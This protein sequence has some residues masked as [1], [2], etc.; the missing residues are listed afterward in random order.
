MVIGDK[1]L[2]A[3]ELTVLGFL[4]DETPVGLFFFWIDG[5][6]L[7]NP[8]DD[9][10]MRGCISW[11]R[12]FYED[13]GDRCEPE[14][15]DMELS[16]AYRELRKAMEGPLEE[17][18]DGR[19]GNI[20]SRF[21][22]EHIGMSSFDDIQI[23]LIEG[24]SMEQRFVWWSNP[25]DEHSPREAYVPKGEFRKRAEETLEWFMSKRYW[26]GSMVSREAKIKDSQSGDT[27]R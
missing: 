25:P 26:K 19:F 9:A 23:A 24:N 4:D 3:I 12:G 20:F 8:E 11:L 5:E 13:P 7:G 17:S 14:L 27:S 15:F 1:Q 21:Y 10:Y 22:I 2:F 16:Q 6:R 18:M